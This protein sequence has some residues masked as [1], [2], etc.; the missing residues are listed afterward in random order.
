MFQNCFDRKTAS[1]GRKT[2]PLKTEY[3]LRINKVLLNLE[4]TSSKYNILF[5]ATTS[6]A[7]TFRKL[8]EKDDKSTI[9]S[10]GR[11]RM[12][13]LDQHIKF[14]EGNYSVT[15]AVSWERQT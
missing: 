6:D 7:G 15:T 2:A 3:K 12:V 8:P 4:R 10:S 1:K 5:Q 11:E 14:L 9:N 13:V